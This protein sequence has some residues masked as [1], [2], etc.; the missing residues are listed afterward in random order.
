MV[1]ASFLLV[2]RVDPAAPFPIEVPPENSG[3]RVKSKSLYKKKGKKDKEEAGSSCTKKGNDGATVEASPTSK[4][5]T[6]QPSSK[7]S[8][9]AAS[10]DETPKASEPEKGTKGAVDCGSPTAGGSGTSKGA[11]EEAKGM[12]AAM[13]EDSRLKEYYQPVTMR[14]I[15]ASAKIL[16]PL[17]RVAKP[18]DQVRKYMNEVMDRAERAPEGFLAFR[19][20][21]DHHHSEEAA[22]SSQKSNTP[23][24]S[25]FVS[26]N[27]QAGRLSRM[28]KP[29][30]TDV[31]SDSGVENYAHIPG[32]A[33]DVADE[34]EEEE[35]LK[36]FYGPPT[37]IPPW[38]L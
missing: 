3:A 20:P 7:L 18:A 37:S 28:F 24:S 22:Q 36:D 31:E 5:G 14:I 17:A 25:T 27:A 23:V 32:Y 4:A 29:K 9:Q 10:G 6:I 33:E 13:K 12:D 38:G 19:L 26:G 35:E 16:E 34:E 1:I 21:R 11:G 8:K 2:R 15:S 30:T